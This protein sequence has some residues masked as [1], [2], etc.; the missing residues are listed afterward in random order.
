MQSSGQKFCIICHYKKKKRISLLELWESCMFILLLWMY[1]RN[2]FWAAGDFFHCNSMS[3]HWDTFATRLSDCSVTNSFNVSMPFQMVLYHSLN[4]YI[5]YLLFVF[6]AVV[7]FP[8]HLLFS[9]LIAAYCDLCTSLCMD[10]ETGEINKG[11]F[12][13]S[14]S[15]SLK[16]R[17]NKS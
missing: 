1:K 2:S 10:L 6:F 17:D 15:L 16:V 9:S 7:F 14:F 3:S 5:A 8:L 12:A 4:I 13:P 11:V